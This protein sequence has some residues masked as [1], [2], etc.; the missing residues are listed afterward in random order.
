MSASVEPGSGT[1]SAKSIVLLCAGD[2]PSSAG[3]MLAACEKIFFLLAHL[4]GVR[5]E[6]KDVRDG[7]VVSKASTPEHVS[8][9]CPDCRA[10]PDRV[11]SLY[12]RRLADTPS[13]G[14][15]VVI[16]LSV[17]RQFCDNGECPRVHTVRITGRSASDTVP[18]CVMID[19]RTGDVCE[20]L[21]L[22]R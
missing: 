2:A 14:Q 9:P 4:A 8:V 20:G 21:G 11:H 10:P 22:R 12:G 13:G 19:D 5:L 16:D 7:R 1:D 6:C 17:R 3:W 15:G 18:A